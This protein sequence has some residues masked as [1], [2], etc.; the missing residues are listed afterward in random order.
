MEK[1]PVMLLPGSDPSLPELKLG[2]NFPTHLCALSPPSTG[3]HRLGDSVSAGYVKEPSI[4][5]LIVDNEN[6]AKMALSF[7]GGRAVGSSV[8]LTISGFYLRGQN[9]TRL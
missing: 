9:I 8:I 6:H 2:P 5:T 3:L 1:H 4:I 7:S